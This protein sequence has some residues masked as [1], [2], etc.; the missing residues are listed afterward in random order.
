[1][2][3]IPPRAC[4]RN[5]LVTNPQKP[6]HCKST[7]L[8]LIHP[9]LVAQ[10]AGA[11]A[12]KIILSTTCTP[13]LRQQHISIPLNK[14]F[15]CFYYGSRLRPLY[16]PFTDTTMELPWSVITTRSMALRPPPT[17]LASPHPI[18]VAPFHWQAAFFRICVPPRGL[19]T[20]RQGYFY[21]VP[22]LSLL[23]YWTELKS[24]YSKKK[25]AKLCNCLIRLCIAFLYKS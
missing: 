13:R 1:M 18:A 2:H 12:V 4:F 15:N 6:K 22:L 7:L 23:F 9:I 21:W 11:A 5:A 16:L 3:E 14:H 10:Q 19:I 25:R 24:N 8:K 17:T 20:S